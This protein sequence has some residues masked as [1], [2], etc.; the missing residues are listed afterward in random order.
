[1][2][3]VPE[4]VRA[5]LEA[6]NPF[7]LIWEDAN[8]HKCFQDLNGPAREIANRLVEALLCF[9]PP[10][11]EFEVIGI[12]AGLGGTGYSVTVGTG[13]HLRVTVAAKYQEIQRTVC[14]RNFK[15]RTSI[16]EHFTKRKQG[17]E[18]FRA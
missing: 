15:V 4:E 5:T 10:S 17:H 11:Q 18:K 9:P 2:K 6:R 1:M 8:A 16:V 13:T 12:V 14:I 3:S 7:Q